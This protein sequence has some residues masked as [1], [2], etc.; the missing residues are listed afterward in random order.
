V[1]PNHQPPKRKLLAN[2]CWLT[3]TG[4]KTLGQILRFAEQ[5]F[6]QDCEKYSEISFNE[7]KL[8]EKFDISRDSWRKYYTISINQ[9]KHDKSVVFQKKNIL[10]ILEKIKVYIFE[11]LEISYQTALSAD[12]F[13]KEL[14][15]RCEEYRI[16][17]EFIQL[18]RDDNLNYIYSPDDEERQEIEQL[19]SKRRWS[20]EK[21]QPR[22]KSQPVSAYKVDMRLKSKEQTLAELL[23]YLNCKSQKNKIQD[24][25]KECLCSNQ[26][27]KAFFLEAKQDLYPWINYS[28]INS[29]ECILGALVISSTGKQIRLGKIFWDSLA[30]ELS[31]NKS[32]SGSV[33]EALCNRVG[34]QPIIMII[35][36]IH[37]AKEQISAFWDTF[38]IPL[39]QKLLEK[40]QSYSNRFTNGGL[41]L[42]LLSTEN[43]SRLGESYKIDCFL[44]QTDNL[45]H[46]QMW[47]YP[48]VL[49]PVNHIHWGD[50]LYW[51]HHREVK[52]F[53]DSYPQHQE[54]Y[55][56][57]ENLINKSKL[58]GDQADSLDM[59][60][61]ICCAFNFQ[62]GFWELEPMFDQLLRNPTS[63][64]VQY[65]Q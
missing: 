58:D 29:I 19:W 49:D 46:D 16:L 45:Y 4:W 57:L 43:S 55:Q 53:I 42:F 33:I 28:L 17:I 3:D 32:D 63:D 18:I 5:T 24:Q 27:A 61:G 20:R 9:Q 41:T 12:D 51:T 65:G 15:D 35:K 38:W 14:L 25:H 37:D 40:S 11:S 56:E 34:E 2:R 23:V 64:E 10:T 59:I 8:L 36:E 21:L 50:I 1:S 60:D 6:R 48:I 44:R 26:W 31:L 52:S 22:E 54:V 62:G 47:K 7:S 30:R 13:E 39:Y